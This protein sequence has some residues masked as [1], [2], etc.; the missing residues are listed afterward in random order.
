MNYTTF[1]ERKSQIGGMHGFKSLW[2]P[3]FLFDYQK[4]LIDWALMKGKGA[5]FADTGMG[6]TPMQLVQAENIVRHTNKNVLILTPL[7]VSHQTIEEGKK[8]GIEIEVKF[9]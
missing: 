9:N 4:Y 6:K 8:F 3:D 7:S 1:L 2:L 5:T